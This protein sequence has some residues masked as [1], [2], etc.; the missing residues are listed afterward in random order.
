MKYCLVEINDWGNLIVRFTGTLEECREKTALMQ[1]AD[2]WIEE[3]KNV[4]G[5]E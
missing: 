2:C 3:Y 1:Y 5:C 4:K